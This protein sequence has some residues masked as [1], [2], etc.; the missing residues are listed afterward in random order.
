MHQKVVLFKRKPQKLKFKMTYIKEVNVKFK[1][2][3]TRNI[4]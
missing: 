2:S 3:K 4:N 1:L